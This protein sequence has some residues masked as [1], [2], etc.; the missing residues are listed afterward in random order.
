[1]ESGIGIDP[2]ALEK[3]KACIVLIE[4]CLTLISLKIMKFNVLVKLMCSALPT[5][6]LTFFKPLVT[7]QYFF[8]TPSSKL[9]VYSVYV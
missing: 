4:E 6:P 2:S 1:M 5:R 7:S 8:C 9:V 3:G